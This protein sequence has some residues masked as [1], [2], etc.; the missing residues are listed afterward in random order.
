MVISDVHPPQGRQRLGF[1]STQVNFLVKQQQQKSTLF[2][3][4]GPEWGHV[5][6]S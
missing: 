4:M 6:M 5:P 3:G 2:R 1:G